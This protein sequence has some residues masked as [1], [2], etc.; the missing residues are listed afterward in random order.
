M[1]FPG[2]ASLTG[3]QVHHRLK[4]GSPDRCAASPPGNF[5]SDQSYRFIVFSGL[6][7]RISASRRHPGTN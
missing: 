3:L 7:A 4:S 1:N 6:V 5:A 2:G